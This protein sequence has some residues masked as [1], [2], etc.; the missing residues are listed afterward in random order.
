MS[1]SVDQALATLRARE[2]AAAAEQQARA[3]ALRQQLH[4]AVPVLRPEPATAWL[5]G[6]LAWGGFGPS[7]DVDVVV[8]GVNSKDACRI[9][10]ELTAAL[11]TEVEVLR[12]EELPLPFQRRIE[13]EGE[14]LH[15]Q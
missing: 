14:V 11:D 4:R 15:G 8:R 12:F 13:A 3:E 6:S 7:S 2:A 9:E 5:I 1:V 10:M